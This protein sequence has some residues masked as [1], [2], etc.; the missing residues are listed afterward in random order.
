[1]QAK[2]RSSIVHPGKL[3][4]ANHT[5]SSP[6]LIRRFSLS[7]DSKLLAPNGDNRRSSADT[8]VASK[9]Q[10]QQQQQQNKD[11][12]KVKLAQRVIRRYLAKKRYKELLAR[13][14]NRKF[15]VADIYQSEYEHVRSL[16]TMY[17]NWVTPIIESSVLPI[18]TKEELTELF[19]Y[20]ESIIKV[21][22]NL[23]SGLKP[24]TLTWNH[25]ALIGKLFLTLDPPLTV[26]SDYAKSFQALFPTIHEKAFSALLLVIHT[27]NT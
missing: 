26:Y 25:H 4:L 10:Q 14:N 12:K 19:H 24:F 15:T 16:E 27:N 11:E 1:M 7:M 9:G 23:V 8:L 21:T 18:Q 3:S 20:Y 22:K 2:N 5:L 13:S 17:Q 6:S